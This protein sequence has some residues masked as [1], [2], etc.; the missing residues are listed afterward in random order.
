M[1]DIECI[2]CGNRFDTESQL[3]PRTAADTF[4]CDDCFEK[5]K[6]AEK[7]EVQHD[8]SR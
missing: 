8:E 5:A 7:I 4:K 1:M 6:D 3:N 2:D